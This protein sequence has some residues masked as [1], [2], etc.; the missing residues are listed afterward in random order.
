MVSRLT[1]IGNILWLGTNRML[2]DSWIN[3]LIYSVLTDGIIVNASRIRE[4]LSATGFIP[5]RKVKVLYRGIN[6]TLLDKY[7]LSDDQKTGKP[8]EI[9]SMGRLDKNKN[10]D[11]LLREFARFL[12]MRPGIDARLQILGE[13]NERPDLERLIDELGLSDHV[14]L[15]GFVAD[16]YPDLARSDV[17]AMTSK[18]EGLSISLLEAMY[19]GNAP[20]STYGGGGVTD[21]ITDGQNGL[22]FEYG[23]EKALSN[24]FLK[25][26]LEP[27]WRRQI[28]RAAHR[29]VSDRYSATC[30]EKEIVEFCNEIREACTSEPSHSVDSVIRNKS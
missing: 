19:L 17:F 23:D 2:K 15:R 29:S 6:S 5:E 14:I 13:G 1:G 12:G 20:V 25:L 8:M 16:P 4:T 30:I 7:L 11:L 9:T 3:R 22:L 10:H 28:S 26:Y 18:Y 27:Q 21:I 24:H